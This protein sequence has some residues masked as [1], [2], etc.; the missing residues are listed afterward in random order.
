MKYIDPK[1]LT[2]GVLAAS[3]VFACTDSNNKSTNSPSLVSEAKAATGVGDKWDDKQEWLFAYDGELDNLGL[4][5][6]V[7][8]P[9]PNGEKE[10][11][12]KVTG[13]WEPYASI[14]GN[15]YFRKRIK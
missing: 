4:L 3:L 6:E 1:S 10:R 9:R 11:I 14:T 15:R 12:K 7:Q 13:G 2:I 8:L 5:T